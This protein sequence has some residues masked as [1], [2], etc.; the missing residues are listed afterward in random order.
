MGQC[1]WLKPSLVAEV[2]FLEWTADHH[3]RHPKFAGLREDK[4]ARNVIREEPR[5]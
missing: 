3:L 5:D 1:R 4:R 2:Q